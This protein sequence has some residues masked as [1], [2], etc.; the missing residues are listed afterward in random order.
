[1]IHKRLIRKLL[2]LIITRPDVLSGVQN[3]KSVLATCKKNSY[4]DTLRI[5]RYIKGQPEQEILI[6]S[7]YNN[8]ITTFYD[9]DWA[10]CPITRN[11]VTEYFI[12]FEESVVS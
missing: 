10:S 8:S 2:Y 7:K 12:K 5:V 4:E 3:I 6:S 9:A 1:M 11:F